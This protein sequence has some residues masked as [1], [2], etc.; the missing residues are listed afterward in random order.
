MYIQFNSIRVVHDCMVEYNLQTIYNLEIV[1]I[2]DVLV[3][4][5]KD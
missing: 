5:D 2:P 4:S 1:V 3:Q